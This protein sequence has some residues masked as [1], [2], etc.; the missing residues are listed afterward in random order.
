MHKKNKLKPLPIIAMILVSFSTCSYATPQN[1]YTNQIKALIQRYT[2]TG[3]A[4]GIQV[5]YKL[6]GKPIQ[7]VVS[8]LGN[9]T[10][11]EKIKPLSVFKAESVTKTFTALIILHL[12]QE[13]QINLNTTL[14][15]LTRLYPNH[16]ANQLNTLITSYPNQKLGGI[17][18][19]QLLNQTSHLIEYNDT[20]LWI[21]RFKKF[22]NNSQT[23][24]QLAQLSLKQPRYIKPGF[25]YA[26]VN[27][28]LLGLAIECVTDEPYKNSMNTLLQNLNLKNSYYQEKWSDQYMFDSRLA[29]GYAPQKDLLKQKVWSV[30]SNHPLIRHYRG[31]HYHYVN[32]TQSYDPS[33]DDKSAGSLISN[34]HDLTEFA[35]QTFSRKTIINTHLLN[36]MTKIQAGYTVQ[37]HITAFP[38]TLYYGLGV[39][40]AVLK[41]GETVLWHGGDNYQY[42]SAY[43]YIPKSGVSLSY[44]VNTNHPELLVQ[45]KYGPGLVAGLIKIFR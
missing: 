34:S 27:Y 24:V 31:S 42:N 16:Y 22:F 29:C 41:N 26:N 43:F 21:K 28:V 1:D 20:Q 30:F 37:T 35:N 11:A 40:I 45:S 10:A 33:W 19:Y 6:P 13:K 39:F 3:V 25:H 38:F 36:L 17:R 12:I 2:K 8:G 5:S 44:L 9:I 4:P 32:I 18:I 23:F 7:T 15:D 14:S